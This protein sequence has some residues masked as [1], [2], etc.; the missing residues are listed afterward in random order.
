MARYFP[1]LGGPG[2]HDQPNKHMLPYFLEKSSG[3]NICSNKHN[4]KISIVK[5]LAKSI[6]KKNQKVF[7]IPHSTFL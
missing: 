6:I 2:S 7:F 4:I 5:I 1:A 3:K